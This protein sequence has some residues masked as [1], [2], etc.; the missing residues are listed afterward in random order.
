[1]VEKMERKDAKGEQLDDEAD[2][3]RE[4]QRDRETERQREPLPTTSVASSRKE[5]GLGV[6]DSQHTT[7]QMAAHSAPRKEGVAVCDD[8]R[9]RKLHRICIV[10]LY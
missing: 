3:R 2:V 6:G 10:H 8:E 9:G 4:T 5:S 1:M 7:W